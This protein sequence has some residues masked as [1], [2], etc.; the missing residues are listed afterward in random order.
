MKTINFNVK[1]VK[2][3]TNEDFKN[4]F[5]AAIKKVVAGTAGIRLEITERKKV[6]CVVCNDGKTIYINRNIA[7]VSNF[8]GSTRKN[9]KR[10]SWDVIGIVSGIYKGFIKEAA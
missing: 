6:F 7:K 8:Y 4:E 5:K 3:F 10:T 2:E 1:T 9:Y